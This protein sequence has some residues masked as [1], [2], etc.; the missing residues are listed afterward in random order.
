MVCKPVPK[1]TVFIALQPLNASRSIVCTLLGTIKEGRAVYVNAD[2]SI[3][4]TVFGSD[5]L[6]SLTQFA[7]ALTPI[8]VVPESTVTVVSTG[9]SAKASSRISVTP[10]PMTTVCSRA[11]PLNAR[12]STAVTLSGMVTEVTE[13]LFIKAS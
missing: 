13:L 1:D 5:R 6:D 7:K 9:Q 4:A 11:H 8:T 2:S 3:T 10:P 12:H